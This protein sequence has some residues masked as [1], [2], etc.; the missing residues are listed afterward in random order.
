MTVITYRAAQRYEA[1]ALSALAFRAKAYWGYSAQFMEA[2]R[3]ELTYSSDDIAAESTVYVV[4]DAADRI[5]GFVA[6][7]RLDS[8]TVEI[9]ALFVDPDMLGRGIGSALMDRAMDASRQLGARR[10]LIQADPNAAEFYASFGA[11][12]CGERESASIPGRMLPLYE[13]DV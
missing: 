1:E 6:V 9:D 4:A 5:A 8:D 2:C 7:M 12:R 11:R 3:E 13:L 10:L